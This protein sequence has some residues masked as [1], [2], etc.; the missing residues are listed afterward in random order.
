MRRKEEESLRKHTL[1]LYEG[2]FDKLTSFY[3]K[4]GA[5]VIIRNLVRAH[6]MKVET[7]AA[8]NLPPVDLEV[9]V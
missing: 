2:D 1:N 4:V 5:A 9:A 8:Q 6:I 7:N 3:P